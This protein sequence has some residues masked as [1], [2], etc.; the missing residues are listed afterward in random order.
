MREIPLVK[1]QDDGPAMLFE[2]IGIVGLGLMG[3]S[4]ALA[5]RATWPKALVIGVDANDVLE[6]AMVRHA[7]DV[8][9]DDL[10]MLAEADLVVL[11][12]P[13][14]VNLG[15]LAQLEEHVSGHAIVTD[16]G[17]T[18]RVMMDAAR[19]LPDRLAF[20]GGHPFAG[21]AR[22]GIASASPELFKRRPWFLTPAPAT[23]DDVVERLSSFVKAIGA[24][25]RAIDPDAHDQ[26]MAMV[27]HVP[28]IAV[29]A[30][31]R[32]IGEAVGGDGLA[33]AGRGLRDTTRLAS[34]SADVW[35]DVASTNAE[36]IGAALD[37]LIELLTALRA[38]LPEGAKLREVFDRACAWRRVLDGSQP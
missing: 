19:A 29:S 10:G 4:L 38:D 27:S 37:A 30:L 9:A 31:M 6:Q 7:I 13:V 17:S 21:A 34:S 11:A 20:V 36:A 23:P 25:P 32:V 26:M 14:R 15:L 22:S 12:A 24:A 8:A 1:A 3:G 33:L 35:V 5:C 28:Q 2:R 18:K 16:L